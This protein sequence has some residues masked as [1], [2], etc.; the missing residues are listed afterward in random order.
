MLQP[1]VEDFYHTEMRLQP[2]GLAF[3]KAALAKY[4]PEIVVRVLDA[5][6]GRGRR[7]IPLPVELRYLRRYFK[8]EE[9]SPFSTF[10]QYYRFGMSYPEIG[11]MIALEDPDLIGI[12]CS[13]SAYHCEVLKTAS[14]IKDCCRAPVVVGG[15]HATAVPESLLNHPA[16]DMLIYGAGERPLVELVKAL[17]TDGNLHHVPNLYFKKGSQI[18]KNPAEEN[19]AI[20][21]IDCPDFSDWI[22]Q[23]YQCEGRPLAMVL[24][25]RGCP[26]GC[27]FCSVHQ[28]FGRKTQRRKVSR[29]LE[30]LR[31]RYL[32]GYRV[33]DFEDDHFAG[34]RS[35][36]EE[37]CH[38]IMQQFARG[39]IRLLAMNGIPFWHLDRELLRLMWQAGFR[40]LNL[41][42]VTSNHDFCNRL[43]RPASWEIFEDC[44]Q[45]A[46]A[47]GFEM[48]AYQILGLP[49]EGMDSMLQTM[50]LLAQ[51]PVW[52][53]ASPFYQVPGSDL[54]QAVS[55]FQ[56]QELV[57]CRLTAFAVE[58]EECHRD[59][60]FTL[61]VISRILNFLKKIPCQQPEI[62][63]GD[64][65]ENGPASCQRDTVGWDILRH[66][67]KEK[68]WRLATPNGYQLQKAFDTDLF[69]NLWDR[70]PRIC[71]IK[72]NCISL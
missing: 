23:R 25:S 11:R 49:G 4:L 20:D 14:A 10:F 53:G 71:T 17:Q 46:S 64:L 9:L 60:L 69:F 35:M 33:F 52:I 43:H 2:L 24:A 15:A 16:V 37:L 38:G 32:Q 31:F 26:Q 19:F 51:S 18:H 50:S 70:M 13:F 67:F 59:Q 36:I 42:L 7:T 34:D 8:A 22:P 1:P 21:E 65:L 6:H 48:T 39:E 45:E 72:K 12:S 58:T 63:M 3:L 54:S 30:E 55:T 44:V 41:S 28:V 66:L 47:L 5:H 61:L 27:R 56:K 57:R 40:T 62:S 68:A 29:V